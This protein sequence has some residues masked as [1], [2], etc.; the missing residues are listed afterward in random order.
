VA[1]LSRLTQA[2]SALLGE[3]LYWPTRSRMRRQVE[4]A[5][6]RVEAQRQVFRMPAGLI[7]PSVLTEAV[8]PTEGA[9]R[10]RP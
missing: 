9:E 7:L 1:A 6:F 4:A 10:P 2:G 3:P 5:G 8:R